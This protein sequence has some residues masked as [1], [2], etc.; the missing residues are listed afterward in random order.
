MDAILNES[1]SSGSDYE[2]E[3]ATEDLEDMPSDGELESDGDSRSN[4]KKH[5]K[6]KKGIIARDQIS[7]A[8]AA[9]SVAAKGKVGT[10]P[11]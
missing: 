11:G 4:V 3:P 9:M 10:N 6:R 7:A 5:E 2:D 1:V 8:V